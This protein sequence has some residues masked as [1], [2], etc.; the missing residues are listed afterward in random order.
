[1]EEKLQLV[2]RTLRDLVRFNTDKEDLNLN[3][4]FILA[5]ND[6]ELIDEIRKMYYH[7]DFKWVNDIDNQIADILFDIYGLFFDETTDGENI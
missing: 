3:V 7:R 1:M 4:A 6:D 5:S 2:Q